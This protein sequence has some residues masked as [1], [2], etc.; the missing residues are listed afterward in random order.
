[1]DCLHPVPKR[2]K[3]K[4]STD[5][6][7]L[8]F[9]VLK[10][11]DK[12]PRLK[13]HS[14][15]LFSFHNYVTVN[16]KRVVAWFFPSPILSSAKVFNAITNNHRIYSP[17]RNDGK[18]ILGA[19]MLCPKLKDLIVNACWLQRKIME[20]EQRRKEF[21]VEKLYLFASDSRMKQR[22]YTCTARLHSVCSSLCVSLAFEFIYILF[23]TGKW[24][25]GYIIQ[26][27]PSQRSLTDVE[28][29]ETVMNA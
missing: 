6:A 4:L 17:V 9:L 8:S 22:T 12:A 11:A 26:S 16:D 2:M 21:L 5:P 20:Q 10:Q 23:S 25:R 13:L 27:S 19:R 15:P 28:K 1:M 18:M 29:K 3:Y 24:Q 14:I 7:S